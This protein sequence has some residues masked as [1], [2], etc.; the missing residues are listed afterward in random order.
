MKKKV[1]LIGGSYFVGR[2]FTLMAAGDDLYELHLLNRG[3]VKF[4]REGITEYSCDRH[5]TA[6]AMKLLE[7]E[8][9]D[10]VIDFCAY[11][12]G[13]IS[14]MAQVLSGK[15]SHYIY[16]STCSVYKPSSLAAD[17]NGDLLEGPGN[18]AGGEYAY[19][20]LLLE[21]ELT[22]ACKKH[23]MDYTI[24]RPAFIYGPY[25]YAP[26][27]SFF[28][29]LIVTGKPVPYPVDATAKIQFV[30]VMDVGEALIK[31]IDDERAR[32]RIYNLSAPEILDYQSYFEQ[33]KECSGGFTVQ[34]VSCEQADR[35]RI[36]LPFPFHQNEL[37]DG[38]LIQ[39]EL[40]LK[41]TPFDK[42]MKNTFNAFK[43]VYGG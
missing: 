30:Y 17:E 14:S 7:N 18:V 16:I 21:R 41:Y 35:E 38:N 10:T 20:K 43:R 1:L 42:G 32:N 2:V 15:V 12:P 28:V 31:V 39:Q 29:Q 26:R 4:N 8:S 40:G 5:D 24:L 3:R 27:E 9:F 25:N 13:D 11:E 34:N 36:P 19:K 37:Y 23:N 33:L 6:T 22:E